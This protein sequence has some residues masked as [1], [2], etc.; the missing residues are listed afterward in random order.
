MYRMHESQISTSASVRQQQLGQKIR[1]RYWKY[2]FVKLQL[3]SRWIDP[4]LKIREPSASKFDMDIV[5]SALAELFRYSYGE[6]LDTLWDHVTRIYFRVA[7]DCP[8]VISRWIK[9]NNE[10]GGQ[11]AF[12][13]KAK[14][15]VLRSLRIRP[16]GR[17]LNMLKKLHI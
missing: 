6:A 2:I 10:F 15:R 5:D 12:K 4:V 8:D 11:S 7:A 17:L 16:E 3:D 13:T 14:L 1:S 9:L